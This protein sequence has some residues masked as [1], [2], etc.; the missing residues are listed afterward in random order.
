MIKLNPDLNNIKIIKENY[1]KIVTDNHMYVGKVNDL[2]RSYF[3]KEFKDIVLQNPNELKQFV[4]E[5][6]KG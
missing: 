1:Y 3:D 6:Y 4:S 2:C 5:S